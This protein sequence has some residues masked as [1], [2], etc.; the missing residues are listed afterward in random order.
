MKALQRWLSDH[1]IVVVLS[2]IGAAAGG[3]AAIFGAFSAVTDWIP[4]RADPDS[5]VVR[6]RVLEELRPIPDDLVARIFWIGQTDDIEF[7]SAE[8]VKLSEAEVG[9]VFQIRL[10]GPPFDE[11]IQREFGVSLAFG[12]IAVHTDT[13]DGK[14]SCEEDSVVAFS[15]PQAGLVYTSGRPVFPDGMEPSEIRLMLEKLARV[16]QGYSLARFELPL[17]DPEDL[18]AS[19]AT[20]QIEEVSIDLKI[21][22][23]SVERM[24]ATFGKSGCAS[25]DG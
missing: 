5:I 12:V 9:N 15:M 14:F 2:A 18:I 25:N 21:D 10:D 6:G 1:P 23:S 4:A 11:V 24:Y 3:I 22:T 8:R 7:P 13:G 20:F 19:V 17:K 16:P